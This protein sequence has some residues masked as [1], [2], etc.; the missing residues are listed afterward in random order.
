MATNNVVPRH[1][2][3]IENVRQ[4]MGIIPINFPRTNVYGYAHTSDILGLTSEQDATGGISGHQ[5]APT[6]I[7]TN[8]GLSVAVLNQI[9]VEVSSNPNSP[10]ALDLKEVRSGADRNPDREL[11]I[12]T[13]TQTLS[14][15]L[16][17]K[18]AD[19]FRIKTVTMKQPAWFIPD[20][21]VKPINRKRFGLGA[22]VNDALNTLTDDPYTF[23]SNVR[24][25]I[26]KP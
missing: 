12:Y 21:T 9:Q 5:D 10:L 19:L 20:V 6:D 25:F 24:R 17:Q 23:D 11:W 16:M 14:D 15:Q 4:F 22:D 3:K 2:Q 1:V 13:A 7:L 8:R 18:I 26:P